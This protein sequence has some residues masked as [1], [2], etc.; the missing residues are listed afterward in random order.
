MEYEIIHL[1]K[2]KW[3]GTIIPIGYT[4]DKYYDVIVNKTDKGFAIGIEKRDFTEPVTHTPEE[5]NFPDKLY[6]DH[7]ENAYAWGV[8]VND[9]L[10]AAIETDQELWSNRLR[11]TELW[12]AENYQK[13]GIGHALVEM[14]KEQARRQRRRA[15]ILETQS[16]NVNA[17]DFYQHE[18]FTLIGMDTCC[19]KNNDLQRKEVR[20]EFGWFP[21]KKKR[22]RREEVE[23]RMETEEDWYKVELMTQRAFWNNHHL[24]CDEHYL[25]HKMRQDKDFLP[26]LSRIA[27]KD[28]EIIGYI[29]YSKARVVDGEDT[30][31]VVTFGP[32][33]VDPKWQGCGV[34]ELL[35]R[36]T[37]DLVKNK[38]YKGIIIFGEPDYYPRIGFKTCDNFNITSAEGRNFDA[39]MGIELW[40]GS[41]EGIKGKFY[42][43]ELFE[44][45]PKEEVEEYSKKFPKL[46]KLRFPGQWD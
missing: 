2:E 8:L 7:W 19:Y 29:M 12:V 38:G 1:P 30:H 13:Q 46:K 20:L 26:E 6:E 43:S 37:M 17:I 23:I 28:G 31:E 39:F 24:G 9:E 32:L 15:I 40:E 10:V 27:V 41:M 45:L 11:I 42:E 5:Y 35:L 16:C 3:K 4:T 18:G 14:A 22:L 25:V 21:K 44:N 36:E 34:G 33:C